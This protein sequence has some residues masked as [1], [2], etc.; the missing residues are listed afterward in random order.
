MRVDFLVKNCNEL[1]TLY[2]DSPR[3]GNSMSDLKIIKKGWLGS[4]RGKIVFIGT[5][6]MFNE[7]NFEVEKDAVI[8]DAKGKVCMPGLVDAHTHLPFGG[9]RKEEFKM[10]LDGV[11]YME[12]QKKGMGIKSTVKAT[13]EIE[14]KE[15]LNISQKRLDNMLK[16][17]ATTIEAKSGYGLDFDT[18]IK[19]LEVLKILNEIHPVDIVSTYLGGHDIPPDKDK[20]V[21]LN[22][23]INNYIPEIANK[24]LAL[25]FDAF[26]EEGVYNREETERMLSAAKKAGFL[27][28]LHADEF[29]DKGGAALAVEYDAL[30]AEHLVKI[31]PD[32]IDKMGNSRTAAVILPGVLFFLRGND[33]P[34]IRE[35]INKDVIIALGSDYN[36]GSSHIN[37][38]F[39]IMRLSVFTEEFKIEEAITAATINS[40]YAIGMDKEVGSLSPGKKTDILILNIPSY[41]DIF[42]EP[43]VNP[44][45]YIIKEGEIIL[46]KC[47]LKY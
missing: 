21:Y 36:P 27:L 30:S 5:E 41:I 12:L 28:K 25:F 47:E 13:R 45:E 43:A 38:M 2:G 24:K 17:G 20:E 14:L 16:G 39:F 19:Q 7:Q 3:R 15:L 42:Y 35:M 8:I 37:N 9:E 31:S 10:K 1:I 4:Y 33:K 32:G 6:E 11:P 18:E 22:E 26:I 40:A 29:T 44:I 46:E 34:P 23:L